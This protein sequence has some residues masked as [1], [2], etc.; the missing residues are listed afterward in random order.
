M[1]I[2]QPWVIW[3]ALAL[4]L[5][6]ADIVIAGGSSGFLLMF[7][8]M[9]VVGTLIAMLGFDLN[10]QILVSLLSG[11]IIVPGVLLLMRKITNGRKAQHSQGRMAS[12]TFTLEQQGNRLVVKALGD[13]YPVKS[14]RGIDPLTLQPGGCVKVLRFEGITA[15]VRPAD[16]AESI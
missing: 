3:L 12:E 6:A 9:A 13:V 10:L 16:P 4:I 14:E 7:A 11:V 1:N 8:L 2:L 15:I 5:F